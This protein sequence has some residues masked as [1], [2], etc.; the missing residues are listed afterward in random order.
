[1]ECSVVVA[2]IGAAVGLEEVSGAVS[3]AARSAGAEASV[4]A[5]AVPV[6]ETSK[7]QEVKTGGKLIHYVLFRRFDVYEV[8]R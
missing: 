2:P 7:S 1:M 3:G 5:A 6:G 8:M 4:A